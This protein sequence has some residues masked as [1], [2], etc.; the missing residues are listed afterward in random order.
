M[1]QYK[2]VGTISK[3]AAFVLVILALVILSHMAELVDIIQKK[4]QADLYITVAL[5]AV[6][7][8]AMVAPIVLLLLR[9]RMATVKQTQLYQNLMK[10][11]YSIPVVAA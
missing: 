9:Q 11:Q 6:P 1:A 5:R 2:Q 10:E 7:V 4:E 8:L 3:I